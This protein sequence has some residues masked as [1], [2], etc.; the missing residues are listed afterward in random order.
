MGTPWTWQEEFAMTKQ[1]M[2]FLEGVFDGIRGL[3][4]VS[5]RGRAPVKSFPEKFHPRRS[6]LYCPLQVNHSV[7]FHLKSQGVPTLTAYFLSDMNNKLAVQRMM[8]GVQGGLS[9]RGEQIR[10]DALGLLK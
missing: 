1:N 7:F 8:F 5:Q 10:H 6:H 2:S 4:V 9:A 3:G